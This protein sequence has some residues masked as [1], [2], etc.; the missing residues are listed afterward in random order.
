MFYSILL[1]VNICIDRFTFGSR[2]RPFEKLIAVSLL[3]FGQPLLRVFSAAGQSALKHRRQL[4]RR[5][6]V[7]CSTAG[8]DTQNGW[9]STDRLQNCLI[10]FFHRTREMETFS[11]TLCCP[12]VYA[13]ILPQD[14]KLST[15][16]PVC[17]RTQASG[18]YCHS[19]N[20]LRASYSSL[21]DWVFA[22]NSPREICSNTFTLK[23]CSNLDKLISKPSCLRTMATRT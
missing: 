16:Q 11:P 4:T 8:L 5:C 9:F 10:N 12:T 23:I 19:I 3:V 2:T 6:D 21:S 1:P 17:A 7:A 20:W 15:Y 18:H 13:R 14:I 22:T